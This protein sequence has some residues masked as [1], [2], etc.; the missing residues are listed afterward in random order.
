MPL[1]KLHTAD[2][3]VFQCSGAEGGTPVVYLPGVHGC[4]TPLDKARPLFAEAVRLIEVAYPLYDQWT[5]EHYAEALAALLDELDLDS[6]HVVGES[7]GSLVGWQFGLMYPAHARS[8]ILVGGF[9]RAP[10]MYVAATA[11][12]GLSILPSAAFDMIVDTYVSYKNR[13]G[14]PRVV[15]GVKSYPAVRGSRGQRATANRMRLI[16]KTDF[17]HRLEEINFPVRYIGGGNDRV[18][19]VAREVAILEH[20]LPESASFQSHLIPKASHAII[21]SSPSTTVDYITRWILEIENKI[22]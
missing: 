15:P 17:R 7:F 5:L 12:L 9:C 19:P 14:E 21:A 6:V 18:I 20:L 3:F 11:S 13:R 10:G 1:R 22:V 8:H 2:R 4:W 16:Q